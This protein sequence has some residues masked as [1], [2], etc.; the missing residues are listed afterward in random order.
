VT[1]VIIAT[2]P[3]VISTI[4]NSGSSGV[5]VNTSVTATFSQPIDASTVNA[6]T[7][8]LKDNSSNNNVLGTISISSDD[9]TVSFKPS[10]NLQSST[11]H[12]ATISTG[13]RDLEGKAMSTTK[14]WSFT[15]TE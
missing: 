4:P 13:I 1:K 15:T 8:T 10:A 6:N 3:T 5:A 7:F 11:L 9:K 12:T 14:S 2:A